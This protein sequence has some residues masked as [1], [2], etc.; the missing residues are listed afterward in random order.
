MSLAISNPDGLHD[1]VPF[2]YSHVAAID[3]RLFLLA[4]QYSSDLEGEVTSDDFSEQVRRS[5][6]NLR[7]VLRSQ[8]LDYEDVAHLRTFIVDHDLD[9]L[10]AMGAVIAEIWGA[11]PPP[12]TLVGVATLAL[13]RM[14]FEVEAI[15]V[16][17]DGGRSSA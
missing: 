16:R 5:F 4:G 14:Q 2:S 6:L 1:P 13:P 8:G 3:D 11:T 15:A 17:Q 7:T 9:K 10:H 12:Q